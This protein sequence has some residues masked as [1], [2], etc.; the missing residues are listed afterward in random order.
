MPEI[1]LQ[2]AAGPGLDTRIYEF[3]PTTNYG[4]NNSLILSLGSDGSNGDILLKF[5][6]SAIPK[7]SQIQEATLSL[8]LNSIVG[9]VGTSYISRLLSGNSDWTEGGATW[10]KR[11]GSQNWAGSVG[12]ETVG[13]DYSAVPLWTGEPD[14]T[15]GQFTDFSLNVSEFQVLIDVANYGF[16]M[17]SDQRSPSVNRQRDYASSDD[18]TAAN[19]PKLFIR[20]IEPSGS[21][22]EYTFNKFDPFKRVRDRMGRVVEPSDIPANKWMFV[23]GSRVPSSREYL[24]AVNDPRAFYIVGV[25]YD[26]DGKVVRIEND[27]NQFADAIIQR[28]SR[29]I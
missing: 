16:K 20:W 18:G 28:L 11:D 4:T 19:R 21:I 13:V 1:T 14:S 7:G 22:Y 23:E 24:S 15:T 29:G 5:D 12:A 26:E 2:P 25:N 3:N 9:S 8:Y 6:L 17:W 27:R 10:N